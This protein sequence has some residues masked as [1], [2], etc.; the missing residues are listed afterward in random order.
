MAPLR[1]LGLFVTESCNLACPYCFAAN[2]ERRFVDEGLA[3]AAIDLLLSEDNE[4]EQVGLTLWGGE[5]LLAFE[6]IRRL[7]PYARSRADAL[8]KQLGVAIPTNVTL[9][10]GE[11]VD[12]LRQHDVRLSLSLDGAEAAQARRLTAGGRSSW[13]VVQEK[14][15]LIHER[16]GDRLPGVRM[17]VSPQTAGDFHT[18]VRFFLDQGFRQVYFAPVVEAPW[19]EAELAAYEAGQLQLAERWLDEILSTGRRVCFNS[20]DKALAWR[21][22]RR[23]ADGQLE[24]PEER[25]IICGAGTA[26]LAVDIDGRIFPCH[27]FVF[28][29]KERRAEALGTVAGGLPSAERIRP[30]QRL[31]PARLGTAERLCA[32]CE[33]AARC[34][35]TCPA[36]NYALTGA[37]DGVHERQCQLALVE[38]R[39]VDAIE[40]RAGDDEHF[41]RYVEE[42]LMKVYSGPGGLSASVTA[43]FTR[44]EEADPDELADRAAAILEGLARDRRSDR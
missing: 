17:T 11:M 33:H 15:R 35:N 16:Y 37:I 40:A 5:P 42:F 2:M 26:M 10:T 19:S 3:R 28:Y 38:E 34:F 41:R 9:L 4:A 6:L 12:W 7:V 43:L 23:R 44:L 24:Q 14:L 32:R 36:L 1:Q 20:W 30:Y 22:L 8:G 29:D 25:N 27:R 18:N 13:P 31:D 39:V 21:E